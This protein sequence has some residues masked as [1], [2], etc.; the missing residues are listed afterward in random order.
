M[1]E[2]L[3][4][5]R[6]LLRAAVGAGVAGGLGLGLP[7]TATA[8]IVDTSAS[9]LAGPAG[10]PTYQYIG[11]PFAKASLR[12][13]PTNELIFPCVRG[14]YDKITSPLGRYYLYY[15]P[16]DAPGGICLAYGNSLSDR[17]T[18]YPNNPI[19]SNNWSPHYSVSHV[20]SPH[21]IW[22]PDNR[23][24]YLYFHGENTT[25]RMAWSTDGVHFTYHGR[26]LHTGVIPGTTETSY[27]RVFEHTVPGLGNRYVMIFMG[28]T[29]GSRKIFWA[30]SSTGKNW[31]FDPTPLVSPGPDGQ[32]DIAAPALLKR[33]GTAYVVYHGNSGNMFL[34]EVGNSFDREVHLGVFHRPLAGAPDSGRSAA[35]S[36][37]TDGGVEYMFYEAGQRSR[38]TIAVARA[39]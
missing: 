18:E 21:I 37:G 20:S 14:V 32:S 22:N 25:T 38:S 23:Q 31:Q 6:G 19:V 39:V 10:F 26:V 17:F 9:T 24:F 11:T 35:A 29:N 28:V 30:W 7:Q 5:C 34:T 12:Y 33:N 15:A 16:H 36:F 8:A 27:A 4:D 3:L 1:T 2:P 13:N